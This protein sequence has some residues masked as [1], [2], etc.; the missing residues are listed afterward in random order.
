MIPDTYEAW[1]HCI[2]I[3]CGIPLTRAF[4]DQRLRELDDRA[5]Y[6]TQQLF[7]RYGDDHV[8]QLKR[9]FQRAAG[10]LDKAPG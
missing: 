1:R 3:D 7:R 8:A 2:E 5:I 9:W 4:I 6:S 10:E